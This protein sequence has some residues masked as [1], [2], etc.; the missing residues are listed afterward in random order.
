MT[1]LVVPVAAIGVLSIVVT[2]FA[3]D[4]N[5]HPRGASKDARQGVPERSE[6]IIRPPASIPP[7]A[8]PHAATSPSSTDRHVAEFLRWKEQHTS[9]PR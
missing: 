1:R 8:Y 3:G 9:P 5:P 2:A 7:R 6:P 4:R